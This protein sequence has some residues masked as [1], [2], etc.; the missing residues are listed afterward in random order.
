MLKRTFTY[1]DFDGNEVTEDHYFHLSPAELVEVELTMPENS[2]EK[3]IKKIVES[4]DG[5]GIV[6]TMKLI[7]LKSYG[8]RHED[9]RRF[10]KT[11]E[12]RDAFS[13]TEAYSQL[14]VELA[15]D[16]EAGA[17][18]IN[19]VLPNKSIERL[20]AKRQLNA[21]FKKKMQD[22]TLEVVAE[23]PTEDARVAPTNV[24]LQNMSD[25]DL[26]LWRNNNHPKFRLF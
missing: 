7:I 8:V 17:E 4:R 10:V 14:F 5:Q 24:D 9:G 26:A 2:L 11:D 18:F 12:L 15:T 20:S 22:R 19:G 23:L 21:D 1:E 13:Q 25:A 16:A 6:D 3:Q